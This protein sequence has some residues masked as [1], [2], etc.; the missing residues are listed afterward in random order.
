MGL[1]PLSVRG[2]SWPD[3]LAPPRLPEGPPRLRGDQHHRRTN[4]GTAWRLAALLASMWCGVHSGAAP[5]TDDPQSDYCLR[6]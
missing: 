1:L 2:S 3:S 5:A 4:E 6:M